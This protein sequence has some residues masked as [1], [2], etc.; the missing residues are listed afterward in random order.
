MKPY[1]LA[2]DEGTTSARAILFDQHGFIIAEG[3]AEFPIYYPEI[4]WVE[5]NATEI[6]EAQWSAIESAL[7]KAHISATEIQAIG[8]TNQRETT[9]LWDSETGLPLAPAIVW[10]D[11]RTASLCESKK[12]HQDWIRQKTG[13]VIDPYFSASKIAWLIEHSPQIQEKLSEGTVCFGTIDSWILWQLT[14]GKVHAT[15]VSNASR[16][17]LMNIHTLNWDTELLDFWGIPNTIRLPEIKPSSYFFGNTYLLGEE[18]PIG[19]IAGDQQAATFGQRCFQPGMIKNTYGTGCFLL[20]N[21]G[22]EAIQS[23]HDLITTIAWQI[24]SEVTYALEGAIFSAGAS[25]QWLESVGIL[26]S[27]DDFELANQIEDTGDVYFVPAFAGLGSPYWDADAR[28]LII[29]MTRGTGKAEVIRAALES[30]AYQSE[31]V[32]DA[33]RK[34]SNLP[35]KSLQVDGGVTKNQF[36]MQFQ[37][38]L[39]NVRIQRP[40]MQEA[41]ALG[42]A[43][44]AGLQSGFWS[45]IQEIEELPIHQTTFEPLADEKFRIKRIERWKQA[46]ARSLHWAI[47]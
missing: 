29:G 44:L 6:W 18:I 9:I 12:Q 4:G 41:T 1:L 45:S 16:T 39:S 5:Q 46:V 15:D 38:N 32:L 24:G 30:M 28:A 37:A 42:A 40:H 20:M 10:Q 33:M 13:L 34:D 8:I 26:Q 31:E 17:M 22:K 43:F 2:I 23:K 36:L 35:L 25:I 11:R 19:G 21:T 47:N 14:E 7:E 3:R 27:Y